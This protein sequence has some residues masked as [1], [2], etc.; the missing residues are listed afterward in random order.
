MSELSTG[1]TNPR[2]LGWNQ[3][4]RIGIASPSKTP[5]LNRV[6]M[7]EKVV[8]CFAENPTEN[9][10]TLVLGT[11]FNSVAEAYNFYSLCSWEKGFAIRYGKSRLNFERTKCMQEIVW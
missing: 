3:R 7:F 5:R 11:T 10:M 9:V 1:K 2:A 4:L 6:S 8:R